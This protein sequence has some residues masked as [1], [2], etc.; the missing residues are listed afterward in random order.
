[1]TIGK[2]LALGF[3]IVLALLLGLTVFGVQQVNQINQALTAITDLNAVKQRHA[4]NFRGSVH[5][6]A[7]ALRDVVLVTTK[8]DLD[9]AIADITGR[10]RTTVELI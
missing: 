2:R 3:G 8:A 10:P 7:I 1:M 5:D 4:I 6:R 9:A